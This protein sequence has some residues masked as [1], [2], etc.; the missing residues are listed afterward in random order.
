MCRVVWVGFVC[1]PSSYD[2]TNP[3]QY[4]HQHTPTPLLRD[5][6]VLAALLARQEGGD[7]PVQQAVVADDPVQLRQR[8]GFGLRV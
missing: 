8:L 4:T 1:K 3:T 7:M 5:R 6:D 2:H